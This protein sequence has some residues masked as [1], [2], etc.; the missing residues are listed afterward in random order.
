MECISLRTC[1]SLHQ[2]TSSG[3]ELLEDGSELSVGLVGEGLL[4]LDVLND[5]SVLGLEV[6]EEEFLELANLG[7]LHLVEETTDTSVEDANLLL[8][9]HGDVLLLL[10][11]LGELLTSVEEVLGGSVEI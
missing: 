3:D 7:G 9:A 5:V 2:E 4:G 8:S 11:E 1:S 10:E 6:V